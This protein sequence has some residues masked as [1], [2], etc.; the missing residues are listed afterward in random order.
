MYLNFLFQGEIFRLSDE[1]NSSESTSRSSTPIPV[2]LNNS[3]VHKESIKKRRKKN[4]SYPKV[5]VKGIQGP[6]ASYPKAVD[7]LDS[8]AS[9]PKLTTSADYLKIGVDAN[10]NIS[11]PE[12]GVDGI[13]PLYTYKRCHPIL[14]P[15]QMLTLETIESR[16]LGHR[17]QNQ[18]EESSLP[19][20]IPEIT[21]PS[22][23]Q[24]KT[25][26]D[27]SNKNGVRI[28]TPIIKLDNVGVT[29]KVETLSASSP[30][31]VHK[32][33]GPVVETRKNVIETKKSLGRRKGN[34]CYLY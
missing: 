34:I 17:S 9:Y 18:K 19:G 10:H 30:A 3:P 28:T 11:Y 14:K 8:I 32:V 16:L 33:N 12:L 15:C 5:A 13:I 24:V 2:S 6:E 23:P 20:V 27:V 31:K 29:K 4:V 25:P 1:T 21:Q 7:N 22:V 26:I